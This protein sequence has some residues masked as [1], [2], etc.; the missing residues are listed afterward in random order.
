M[1]YD[2]IHHNFD[3]RLYF[4]ILTIPLERRE[5]AYHVKTLNKTN[6]KTKNFTIHGWLYEIWKKKNIEDPATLCSQL[7]N[8]AWTFI[9][10]NWTLQEC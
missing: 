10:Q 4:G 1:V 2:A 3:V 8:I 9:G 6:I 7:C 5:I